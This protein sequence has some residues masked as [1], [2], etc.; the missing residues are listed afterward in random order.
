MTRGKTWVFC[1]GILFTTVLWTLGSILSLLV[2]CNGLQLLASGN[3]LSCPNQVRPSGNLS[4][5]VWQ[6]ISKRLME[7]IQ[8]FRWQIITSFDVATEVIVSLLPGIAVS[9][10][11][12]SAASKAQV[13]VAFA[14][15]LPSI[16]LSI[17]HLVYLG[18]VYS[19]TVPQL[20]VTDALIFQQAM[21]VW[22]LVSATIPNM[23]GF[24][25]TFSMEM[26]V[27][28][29]RDPDAADYEHQI[30]IPLQTIGSGSYQ[31][32][33][34]TAWDNEEGLESVCAMFRPDGVRHTVLIEHLNPNS[35]LL[36]GDDDLGLSATGSQDLIIRKDM[37]WKVSREPS[38][39]SSTL[40]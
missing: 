13:F 7:C 31:R 14:I 40:A 39:E 23:K 22:S 2:K 27:R 8:Y 21:L 16:P 33:H 37:Q 3:S 15:R 5:R 28:I 11:N 30:S 4:P 12:I 10:I 34:T 36:G 9:V 38:F 35:Q 17:G 20:A 25:R 18:R 26:G 19:S 1:Y 6:I 32:R 24:M 29:P